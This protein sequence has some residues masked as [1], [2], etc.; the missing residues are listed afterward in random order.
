MVIH[1]FVDYS[2]SHF[3]FRELQIMVSYD[4]IILYDELELMWQWSWPI[5][6]VLSNNLTRGISRKPSYIIDDLHT[7]N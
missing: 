6:K 5:L 1:W 7:E 4:R 2:I 3:K